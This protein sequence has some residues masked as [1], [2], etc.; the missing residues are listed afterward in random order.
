[1]KR[2]TVRSTTV[3]AVL[4]LTS[5]ACATR[6]AVE[7]SPD[8]YSPRTPDESARARVVGDSDK[9]P[10]LLK[11]TYPRYPDDAFLAKIQG[12][13]V[14][15][16]VIDEAGRVAWW[17]VAKSVRGLDEAAVQCA[18]EWL[19]APAERGGVPVAV[20]ATIPVSFQIK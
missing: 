9:A 3:V 14:L 4:L 19:F 15:D 16:V 1:M 10:R 11:K 7:A 17:H 8:V 18:R 13:V 2:G 20:K 6:S 5:A 12:T